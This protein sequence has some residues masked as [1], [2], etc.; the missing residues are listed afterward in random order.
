MS[1]PL[2]LHPVRVPRRTHCV[3]SKF[4]NDLRLWKLRNLPRLRTPCEYVVAMHFFRKTSDF[5]CS[6]APGLGP[7]GHC[8]ARGF[9]AAAAAAVCCSPSQ[10][11]V[12]P[13]LFLALVRN[14]RGSK[15]CYFLVCCGVSSLEDLCKQR[16]DFSPSRAAAQSMQA[17][18][19]HGLGFRV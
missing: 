16:Q 13:C 6:T 5:A 9:R 12:A 4:M 10:D 14:S 11:C 19:A 3:M 18:P 15:G 8:G 1:G 2:S 17:S 7:S